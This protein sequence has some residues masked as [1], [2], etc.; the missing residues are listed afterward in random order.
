M[1]ESIYSSDSTDSCYFGTEQEDFG[2]IETELDG[3]Y[4]PC[5]TIRGVDEVSAHVFDSINLQ[6]LVK[7]A[8]CENTEPA[9]LD[10]LAQSRWVE[11]RSAVADN[12]RALIYTLL[13]L[14]YDVDA[15]VR[16]Q[17]A[18]NHRTPRQ[19]LQVLQRDE[20]PFVSYRADLT[21]CRLSA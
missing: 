5:D 1:N 21:M 13:K 14:A 12:P 17:L 16:Y 11:V 7:L 15:D 20:N 4:C 3:S 2:A 6:L 9:V 10:K 19:V 8:E 18:E